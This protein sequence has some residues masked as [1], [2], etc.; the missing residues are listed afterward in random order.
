MSG[1]VRLRQ[2]D[3]TEAALRAMAATGTAGVN[4]EQLARDLGTTKGSF[5][6]HFENRG[7]LLLAA[8][9]RW[10]ELVDADLHAAAVITDSRERLIAASVAGIGSGLDGF[11]DLALGSSDDPVVA[12]TLAR[13]NE[14]RLAW[15]ERALVDC[16]VEVTEAQ[17]R[18]VRGLAAYLGLYQLQRAL[19][20]SFDADRLDDLISEI[21]SSLVE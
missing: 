9:E 13:V 7:A 20:R 2:A 17:D 10:E 8:L 6:H 14:R 19:G 15:I 12:T 21:A 16:G 4:V 3:W 18:A 11:V 5:Y 1:T